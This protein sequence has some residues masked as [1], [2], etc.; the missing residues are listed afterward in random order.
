MRDGVT[1]GDRPFFE[2]SSRSA[3]ASSICS[4][5][6]FFSLAFSSSSAFSRFASFGGQIIH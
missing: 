1:H 6:S 4:A 5:S 3:A 2:K